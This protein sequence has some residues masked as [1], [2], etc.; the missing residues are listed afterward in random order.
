MHPMKFHIRAI[1]VFLFV[2]TTTTLS[3]QKP[4][5]RVIDFPAE[6]KDC[7]INTMARDSRGLIWLGTECGLIRYDGYEF[8]PV[9]GLQNSVTALWPDDSGGIIAGFKNGEIIRITGITSEPVIIKM[10]VDGQDISSVIE[11]PGG[12]IWFSDYGSGL[13]L[14]H[15]GEI[16]R[17]NTGNSGLADD[18][19][20]DLALAGGKI[21]A[22][23]DAGISMIEKRDTSFVFSRLTMDNGLPDV[24]IL[25][26]NR[27]ENGDILAGGYAGGFCRIDPQ[28]E[29]VLFTTAEKGW[30]FG[31]VSGIAAAGETIWLSTENAGLVKY[32]PTT[33]RAESF[34]VFEDQNM[35]GLSG[36]LAG[37]EGGLMA[38]HGTRIVHTPSLSLEFVRANE[39]NAL[40]DV[41]ALMNDNRGYL[42]YAAEDG[43]FRHA[44]DFSEGAVSQKIN[45]PPEISSRDITCLHQDPHGYIWVG[46]FGDGL[47]RLNPGYRTGERFSTKTGFVNDNILSM[48]SIGNETWFATLGGASRAAFDP[49]NPGKFNFE[50]Y[51]ESAGLGNNFIY[52]VYADSK[53]RIWFAT[54][55]TGITVLEN[56]VF[57]TYGLDAG[58]SSEKVYTITE[59]DRGRIW[60]ATHDNAIFYFNDGNFIK[61]D[62]GLQ[63]RFTISALQADHH[64]NLLIV[65]ENG[66][67]IYR[68]DRQTGS[69]YGES[70]GILPI[71][72]EFNSTTWSPNGSIWIGTD[73]GLIRY[74]PMPAETISSPVP[75][76]TS[77]NVM[78]EPV[79]F[80]NVNSFGYD[81]NY[82]I[83]SYA[84]L[85]YPQ[86][87]AVTYRVMLEGNDMDWITTG[88]RRITYSK[89]L[90]GEYTFMVQALQNG[91][92]RKAETA[93]YHFSISNPFWKTWWFLILIAAMLALITFTFIRVRV[94]RLRRIS[95]LENEKIRYQFETLRSQVNPHFL[96]NSFSTLMSA[97]EDDRKLALEYVEKLSVFF[98]NMLELRDKN[99]ITI[100]EE[101]DIAANYIY[102]QKSRYGDNLVV[103]IH[104]GEPERLTLIPP[105]TL[106]LLIENAI[107]HN[108][109][110]NAKPLHI[111]ISDNNG[112]LIIENTLQ[113]KHFV[114]DSTGF[115]LKTIRHRYRMFSEKE[116]EVSKDNGKFVV[117]LPLISQ[118]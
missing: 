82:F 27:D 52:C 92:F 85:W 3:A 105:L 7:R 41:H 54:D 19:V 45:L 112:F 28:T 97:I 31:P 58:L 37:I 39:R 9:A 74:S 88:D 84:G 51:D 66:L 42:W 104:V 21:W 78:F 40:R 90:P 109:I 30:E 26:L 81:R 67:S 23:S 2:V 38:W 68:P 43:L 70:Y 89:L 33:R 13:G 20:Y 6:S 100:A 108:I 46:T 17:F 73:N 87:E 101:L 113:K 24:M 69:F 14:I 48:T 61:I 12:D 64:G 60:C 29:K 103:E 72:P 95:A 16:R 1:F 77:V 79:N 99:L 91:N 56:G 50:N 32:D 57:T 11:T 34:T 53:G 15:A 36:I 63:G 111:S 10:A 118:L 102:L 55:G 22:A 5:F 62:A 93:Q 80:H 44:P 116:I 107:K 59:D 110:S 35:P 65:H 8:R 94:Q 4:H 114:G 71:D 75:L 25:T 18:Y 117:K 106:Q 47:Y 96:F 83:F 86:P 76:I 49:D 98:R 115:G